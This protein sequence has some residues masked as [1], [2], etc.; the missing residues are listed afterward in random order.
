MAGAV[1]DP[2]ADLSGFR[3]SERLKIDTERFD[4]DMKALGYERDNFELGKREMELQQK[5]KAQEA[6]KK[7]NMLFYQPGDPRADDSRLQLL[8]RTVSGARAQYEDLAKPL[9]ENYAEY[10]RRFGI[11][12]DQIKERVEAAQ[13]SDVELARAA[14]GE[15]I[16]LRRLMQPGISLAQQIE[17]AHADP[18]MQGQV[19]QMMQSGNS[20]QVMPA[21]AET[22]ASQRRARALQKIRNLNVQH[23]KHNLPQLP[24]PILQ[25]MMM[26]QQNQPGWGYAKVLE[27]AKGTPYAKPL[28]ELF[29]DYGDLRSIHPGLSGVPV[30]QLMEDLLSTDYRSAEEDQQRE[31]NR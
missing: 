18:E 11:H 20:Q 28:S 19:A 9:E 4:R 21:I 17:L 31:P 5:A 26:F 13:R 14:Q 29:S 10:T 8:D 12:P 7:A 22:I 25:A 30:L 23:G 6:I 15:D 27:A 3:P 16:K 24:T 2:N 1:L